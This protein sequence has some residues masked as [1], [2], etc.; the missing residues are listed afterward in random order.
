[1]P[2]IKQLQYFSALANEKNMGRLASKLYVSQTALSN[3]ISR[4]E[5]ELGVTLFERT[6]S[7]L[8][9][10][11]SGTVYL[12]YVEQILELLKQANSE[13]NTIHNRGRETL[14]VAFNSPMLYGDLLASFMA[15][16]P[17]YTVTQQTCDID[18]IQKAL[19]NM[20]AD[21]I[22]AGL[23]DF[24]SPYMNFRVVSDDKIYVCVPS[25][26]KFAERTSI[27]LDECK[28]EPFIFQPEGT[29]FTRFSYKLFNEVGVEPN[30]IARCDYTMRKKLFE[31]KIG[32]ILASDAIKRA[33]FFDDC[34]YIPLEQ[35]VHRKMA[36]FWK[37]EKKLSKSAEAFMNY[38]VT[39]FETEDKN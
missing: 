3:S 11:Q 33:D 23:N 12:K 19:P 10:T 21:I 13:L 34:V 9:L 2:S 36:L 24:S 16:F 8:V 5:N 30:V 32:I 35:N 37:K 39:Y 1:M 22:L 27:S 38:C 28:E 26:H 31:Q 4:L 25:S 17:C 18:A 6:P 7:G 29:G 20:E 14:N 15:Q